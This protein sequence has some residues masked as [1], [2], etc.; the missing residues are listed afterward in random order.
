MSYHN[1]MI[2]LAEVMSIGRGVES[3]ESV[4]LRSALTE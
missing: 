1:G 3:R 4:V 2:Y